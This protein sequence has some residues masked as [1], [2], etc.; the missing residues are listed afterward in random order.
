M[1]RATIGTARSRYALLALAILIAAAATAGAL[2][3]RSGAPQASAFRGSIPPPDIVAPDFALRDYTGELVRMRDL[4]GKVVL[5]TFLD[6]KC[7][8]ACPIIA[9]VIARGLDLLT[10]TQRGQMVALAITSNPH[11][12]TPAAIRSFLRR[13]RAEGELRYL[14]GSE[15][16][17]RPVWDAFHVVPS[18]DTG[19]AD[20]HSAP[21]RIFDRRGL[22]VSTLHAG[23]DLTPA[24]LAHDVEAA[25]ESS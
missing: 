25:L 17:L 2:L 11:D 4:R 22:W 13:H 21:A 12:D 15:R 23:A 16:A 3:S 10:P 24:N 5:V 18:I 20:V 14:I 9:G 7:T 1:K 6:T 8:E 19:S